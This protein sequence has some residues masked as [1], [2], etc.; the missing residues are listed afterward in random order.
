MDENCCG[1]L[2]WV[3]KLDTHKVV[4]ALA[5]SLDYVYVL[6]SA[7]PLYLTVMQTEHERDRFSVG[8]Q[9]SCKIHLPI[10]YSLTRLIAK[11]IAQ[12]EDDIAK[13]LCPHIASSLKVCVL[14]TSVSMQLKG[15]VSWVHE[16]ARLRKYCVRGD[17]VPLKSCR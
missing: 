14:H 12:M 11:C 3:I 8:H 5:S 10:L 13:P 2:V 15:T 9:T 16:T 17:T 6:V 4:V 7:H 1:E